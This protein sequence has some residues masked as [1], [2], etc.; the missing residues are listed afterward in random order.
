MHRATKQW[1]CGRDDLEQVR[2]LADQCRRREKLRKRALASWQQDMHDL[3]QQAITLDHHM[4]GTSGLSPS[5]KQAKLTADQASHKQS[6]SSKAGHSKAANSKQALQLAAEVADAT[7]NAQAKFEHDMALSLQLTKGVAEEAAKLHHVKI[8]RA[9]SSQAAEEAAD[10][11]GPSDAGETALPTLTPSDQTP[12]AQPEVSPGRVTRSMQAHAT[13]QAA[14]SS[15][16]QS[17]ASTHA[18]VQASPTRSSR[19]AQAAGIESALVPLLQTAPQEASTAAATATHEGAHSSAGKAPQS[20]PSKTSLPAVSQAPVSNALPSPRRDT[21]GKLS[22][23]AAAAEAA[24]AAAAPGDVGSSP[25]RVTRSMQASVSGRS[26]GA[27][28]SANRQAQV[29][30]TPASHTHRQTRS[31]QGT[32]L[33]TLISNDHAESLSEEE[34]EQAGDQLGPVGPLQVETPSESQPN[35]S[36]SSQQQ[37]RSI[38][39]SVTAGSP[40]AEMSHGAAPEAE[41]QGQVQTS[42]RQT[43]SLRAQ[44]SRLLSHQGA[45]RP[46]QSMCLLLRHSLSV[47]VSLHYSPSLA[48][49]L[50]CLLLLECTLQLQS[51]CVAQSVALTYVNAAGAHQSSIAPLVRSPAHSLRQKAAAECSKTK[52]SRA[53]SAS[54]SVRFSLEA[55]PTAEDT[56]ATAAVVAAPD[57]G[58]N[59]EA[60]APAAAP[61]QEAAE[62]RAAESTQ[63]AAEGNTRMTRSGKLLGTTGPTDAEQ[64]T[65]AQAPMGTQEVV[66]G[67]GRIRTTR[68]GRTFSAQTESYTHAET[69]SVLSKR[70]CEEKS[71]PAASAESSGTSSSSPAPEP[72][73]SQAAAP[74]AS[75]GGSMCHPWKSSLLGI[76][77]SLPKD[78]IL[79]DR[80]RP[81]TT[82]HPCHKKKSASMTRR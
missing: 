13:P 14:A 34:A 82:D 11:A 1:W 72:S 40:H 62:S 30:L 51:V 73:L 8:V 7:E 81:P 5:A 77:L 16:H 21:A 33:D 36:S 68:S 32:M 70:N 31:M 54:K 22:Q 28:A 58:A 56:Q 3:L 78:D 48:D 23:A 74:P 2:I 63:L 41:Q 27:I 49:S 26:H 6:G 18:G 75:Q 38:R 35:S 61:D 46:S 19:S 52:K 29:Q 64:S 24:A 20:S 55:A 42:P 66:P 4:L 60:A 43:R 57:S 76:G 12:M 80:G 15:S 39:S 79:S 45:K 71:T 65:Q 17:G 53:S 47:E 10:E 67:T 25:Q 44:V 9:E 37:S 59:M 69:A 50:C